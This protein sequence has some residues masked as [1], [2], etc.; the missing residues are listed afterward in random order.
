M[1][2]IYQAMLLLAVVPLLLGMISAKL[3]RSVISIPILAMSAGILAGPAVLGWIRPQ[4]WPNLHVILREIARITIAISVLGI[5]IRTPPD[6]WKRVLRPTAVLLTLG[7]AGMWAMSSLVAW[8]VLGAGAATALLIGAILTPTDPVVATSIVT[9]PF[10]ENILPD[11]LRSTLSLESGANDGLGFLFVMLP[12]T[13]L[14]DGQTLDGMRV[15][16]ILFK[17]VLG[18]VLLGLGAGWLVARA[19]KISDRYKL[20]EQ[21]SLHGLTLALSLAA[22][23]LS[24]TIG[25]D[26][27]LT[28]FSA[29]AGFCFFA[30]RREDFEE[31]S[32]Q[33]TISKLLTVPIF[34]LFGLAIPWSGWASLGWPLLVLVAGILVLRRPPVVAVLAPWLGGGLC[35]RDLLFAGWFAPIGVAAIFYSL[36]ASEKTGDM[37]FWHVASAMVATSIVIHGVTAAPAVRRYGASSRSCSSGGDSRKR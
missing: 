28:A 24:R 1:T 21:H 19:L 11:R 35:R 20:A 4:D 27:I 16:E 14:M 29:G 18:A 30:D 5:A 2:T 9:G 12:L 36:D 17:E 22:L 3:E 33:E 7:M 34:S 31:Q 32:V 26:G 15:A 37:I 13:V 10:A 8:G 23:G 6:S 25:V